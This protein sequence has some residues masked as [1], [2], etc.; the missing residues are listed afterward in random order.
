[1]RNYEYQTEPYKHQEKTLARSAFRKEFALFLEMGL[2]KSKVLLDN[3][4]VLFEADK[5]NA[6]L[7]ITP[8]GNLRNW[9]K[10]EIP[11]HFP[12]RIEKKVL[13]WQPNHTNK[14]KQEYCSLVLEEHPERLEIMT[15]NVEA[16]STE[17]GLKFARAFVLAHETMIAV[18]EST[19]I[20]NP[21]AKRTK[22]L[23]NLSRE[24]PYKRI[25]TG[26]PVTKTP[27]D[28]Y[29]QCAFLNPLTT[30]F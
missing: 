7:I 14:W 9:D 13:V 4:A 3:A 30:R 10:L 23:L 1:M 29:S 26:F 25:L 12:E 24:A 28:L 21:Q 19:L 22:N 15:M 18:D 5:I 8:K 11:K 6:L 16:F 2:G 17:K 27:L 20:K